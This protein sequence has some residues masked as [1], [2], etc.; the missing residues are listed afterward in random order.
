MLERRDLVRFALAAAACLAGGTGTAAA[1]ATGAVGAG[2]LDEVLR[3]L[4]KDGAAARGLGRRYLAAA[5]PAGVAGAAERRAALE[6]AA[7]GGIW[8]VRARIA[9]DR[10]R[11]FAGLD[12][13][14]VD[15]WVLARSEAELLT[16]VATAGTADA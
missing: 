13:V 2:P 7:A 11:D 12:V 10:E 15:G 5:G 16:V 4:V 9:A 3:Q 8:A 6:A 1:A 14:T